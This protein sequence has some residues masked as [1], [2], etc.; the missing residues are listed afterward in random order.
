MQPRFVGR[1]SAADVVTVANA[2]L[3]FAAA[4]AATVQPSLAARLILLGAIADGLDGVL[5]RRYGSSDAGPMLDSLAD[6]ATF[7]VAPALVAFALVRGRFGFDPT[8]LAAAAVAGGL[9]VA[10]G[11]LR[12]GMYAAFDADG[13]TTEGVQT[14]LAATVL[15]ALLLAN[16]T[17]VGTVLGGVSGPL[18]AVAATGLLAVAMLAPVTYPDL[19]AG[20]ALILGVV[21]ACALLAP[22][23]LDG[24]FPLALLLAALGYLLLSPWLYWRDD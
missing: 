19:L 20:D 16:V 10:A 11:V 9:F 2:A 22:D 23:A 15:A 13:H 6:V 8:L 24:A 4:A 1:L 14:T 21:Q 12:L 7:V 3:G 18:I 5:A 17:A